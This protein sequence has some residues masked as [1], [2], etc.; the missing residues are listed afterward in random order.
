LSWPA[1]TCFVAARRTR[2]L[3]GATLGFVP[4]RLHLSES[5]SVAENLALPD[6]ACGP[7]SITAAS[8]RCSIA[9][10]AAL[11]GDAARTLVGQAQRWR[12]RARC[13]GTARAARRR[14]TANLDD[15][16]SRA[17]VELLVEAA[18]ELPPRW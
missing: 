1:P 12:W 17:V 5:L 9:G 3:R 10:S 2:C 11:A 15:A 7:Q 14:P 6:V 8:R 4:Q 18:H 13:C 16:M